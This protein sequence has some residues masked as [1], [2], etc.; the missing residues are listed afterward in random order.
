M[1]DLTARA[2]AYYSV[3]VGPIAKVVTVPF[4]AGTTSHTCGYT[5]RTIEQLVL[6]GA[7]AAGHKVRV[8]VT[9]AIGLL[10]P[11]AAAADVLEQ[12]RASGGLGNYAFET[13]G[14]V[15]LDT[16]TIDL[17]ATLATGDNVQLWMLT[18]E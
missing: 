6:P 18:P 4:V 17:G 12:S 16:Y 3:S 2:P 14:T 5:L 8:G 1:T 7:P 13:T 15:D 10:N 11:L 9:D